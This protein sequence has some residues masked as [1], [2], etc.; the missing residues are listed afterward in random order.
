MSKGTSRTI[1][2]AIGADCALHT[3]FV[4]H[5]DLVTLSMKRWFAVNFLGEPMDTV[6]ITLSRISPSFHH[7]TDGFGLPELCDNNS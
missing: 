6:S 1:G 2:A 7:V 4:P 5:N 3:N